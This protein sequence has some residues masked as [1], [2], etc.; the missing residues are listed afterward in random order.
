MNRLPIVKS[1]LLCLNKILN[2][3][4]KGYTFLDLLKIIQLFSSVFK[5]SFKWEL[6]NGNHI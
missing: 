4:E 6:H 3:Y 5:T 2:N 1:I